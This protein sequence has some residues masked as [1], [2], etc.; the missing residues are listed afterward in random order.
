MGAMSILKVIGGGFYVCIWRVY[1]YVFK[2]YTS[3]AF[4]HDSRFSQLEK[5]ERY[6]AIIDN[7]SYEP[8]CILEQKYRTRKSTLCL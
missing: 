1:S 8:I 4:V 3:Y 5:S 6:G 7:R 2:K